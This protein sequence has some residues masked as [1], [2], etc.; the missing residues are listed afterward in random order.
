MFS[1][2]TNYKIRFLDAVER[3]CLSDEE[4]AEEVRQ[5]IG[6]CLKTELVSY[7]ASDVIEWEKG[8]CLKCKTIYITEVLLVPPLGGQCEP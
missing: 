8:H 6:T 2:I 3:K 4:F 5:K 7:T 1:P